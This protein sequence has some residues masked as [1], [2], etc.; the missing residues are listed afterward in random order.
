LS[1]TATLKVYYQRGSSDAAE[2]RDYIRH[3]RPFGISIS[4]GCRLMGIARSTYYHERAQ[5]VREAEL[6][7]TI[8]AVCDEFEAN[9]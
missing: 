6:L 2:K 5:R 1:L 3:H 9:A 8:L 4:Q 7:A